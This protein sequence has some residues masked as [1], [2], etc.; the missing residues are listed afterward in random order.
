MDTGPVLIVHLVCVCVCV[1]VCVHMHMWVV[2][3]G[4][5]GGTYVYV[6]IW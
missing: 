4:E 3:R 6:A 5:R 2:N 1:C